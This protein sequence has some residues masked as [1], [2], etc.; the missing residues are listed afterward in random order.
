MNL[1]SLNLLQRKA[2]ESIEGPILVFAGA[3]SG[4]TRVLTYKIAYLIEEINVPCEDILAV[5]FTNKAAQEMNERV[6][7]LLS[8]DT[9]KMNV[10]TFHSICARILRSEIP[11]LGYSRDFGIYDQQDSRMLVKE[12]IQS[13]NLDVKTFSPNSYQYLISDKKKNAFS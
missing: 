5:T 3:G 13:L 6:S 11:C 4:K 9:S 7:Q 12:V 8:I 2:V 10:G 1:D